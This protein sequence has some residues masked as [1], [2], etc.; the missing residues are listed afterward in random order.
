MVSLKLV[1]TLILSL[2]FALNLNDLCYVMLMFTQL[3]MDS[4]GCEISWKL[5]KSHAS[6]MHECVS[7]SP[8]RSLIFAGST[9]SLLV[10]EFGGELFTLNNADFSANMATMTQ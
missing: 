1:L 6:L 4:S 3:R 7:S 2:N 10:C 8:A 5:M 9:R